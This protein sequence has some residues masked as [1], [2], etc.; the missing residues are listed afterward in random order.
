MSIIVI[1]L[2]LDLHSRAEFL[3]VAL[4]LSGKL[5]LSKPVGFVTSH[6]HLKGVC[7]IYF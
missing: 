5:I 3:D 6:A 4:L 7:V 2:S 1:I